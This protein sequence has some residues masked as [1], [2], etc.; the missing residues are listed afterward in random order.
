[1]NETS[2]L[3]SLFLNIAIQNDTEKSEVKMNVNIRLQVERKGEL[4]YNCYIN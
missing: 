2:V 1:M 4:M 3:M